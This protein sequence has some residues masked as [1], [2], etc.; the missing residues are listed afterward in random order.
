MNTTNTYPKNMR[1]SDLPLDTIISGEALDVSLMSDKEDIARQ[2][3]KA[4]GTQQVAQDD[5]D[6]SA[7]DTAAIAFVS[8]HKIGMWDLWVLLA[9]SMPILNV[10][11]LFAYISTRIGTDPD[12]HL[13]FEG[14][15]GALVRHAMQE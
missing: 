10:L 3:F 13:F 8:Q 12:E 11:F 14:E 1:I 6:W 7:A 5:G 15:G 4:F 2:F 9:S